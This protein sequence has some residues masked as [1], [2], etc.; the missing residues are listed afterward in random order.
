MKVI[1]DRFEGEIAYA[2]LEDGS[3]IKLPAVL[4]PDGREGDVF[5]IIKDAQESANRKH[6]IA[7]LRESIQKKKQE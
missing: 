7:A 5:G 2:E 4:F 3:I 6:R 1:I